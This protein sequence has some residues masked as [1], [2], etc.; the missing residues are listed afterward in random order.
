MIRRSTL[1]SLAIGIA[2]CAPSVETPPPAELP[3]PGPD[4]V[5]LMEAGRIPGLA[6]AVLAEGESRVELF[7]VASAESGEVLTD[8]MLFE[9]ASLAKPVFATAVL[10]LAERGEFDLDQPLQE[11]LPYE[12]V[13]HDPR[14]VGLTG[15]IVLSHRTGLPNWGPETLEFGAAPG[16]RFGY[17]GEGYVYLQRAIQEQTGLTLDELVRREVFDPLGMSRSR[18]SWPEGEEVALVTPHDEGGAAQS[19]TVGDIGI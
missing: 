18:F 4:Y 13:S 1:V 15:R 14:S 19:L 5:M 10:R 2:A 16:E 12:R 7:G 11:L 17:S 9:A 3:P 8:E 6:V